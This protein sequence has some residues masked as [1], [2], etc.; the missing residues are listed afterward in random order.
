MKFNKW[1]KLIL[2][3]S[4]VLTLSACHKRPQNQSYGSSIAGS[5]FN[6]RNA[7]TSGLGQE[8]GFGDR[9]NSSSSNSNSN[10]FVSKR[11]YYFSFDSN[12]V[13]SIDYPAIGANADYLRSHRNAKVLLEGHTDPRGSREYNIGLGE[14]RAKAVADI[15]VSKGVNPA[16]IRIVSYGAEKLAA[17]GHSESAYQ[18]DRRVVLVYLRK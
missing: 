11:T 14:R 12:V 1:I 8:S 17:P 6:H 7:Q 9:S 3:G 4:C 5:Y 15:L 18:L 13:R 10:Q 16:Q 2:I